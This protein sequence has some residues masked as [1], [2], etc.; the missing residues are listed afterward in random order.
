MGAGLG[1]GLGAEAS[2]DSVIAQL[3]GSSWAWPLWGQVSPLPH[4]NARPGCPLWGGETEGTGSRRW[5]RS[6]L[7]VIGGQAWGRVVEHVDG[8]RETL[9]YPGVGVQ[10]WWGSMEAAERCGVG[11]CPIRVS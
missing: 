10:G 1:V 9:G 8:T 2:C 4:G 5:A 6:R 3:V 7:W 11:P